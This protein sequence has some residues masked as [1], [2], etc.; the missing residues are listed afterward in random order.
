[1]IG[2]IVKY[3]ENPDLYMR[4]IIVNGKPITAYSKNKEDL[5]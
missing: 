3:P 2:K 5:E 4:T 1:M